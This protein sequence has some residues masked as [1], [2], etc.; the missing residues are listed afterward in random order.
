MA[1]AARSTMADVQCP[2]CDTVVAAGTTQCPSCGLLFESEPTVAYV[3]L[4]D[5]EHPLTPDEAASV[6]GISGWA[7]VVE[8]GPRTGMT[9][10]LNE[11]TTAVGRQPDSEILLD[12]VTVSR[13][14][15]QFTVTVDEL[16]VEDLGSTNGTYVNETRVDQASLNP[17]DQVIIG[18]FQFLVARG[19]G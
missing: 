8:K 2:R 3:E 5:P 15:C 6:D 18:R 17:G 19:D 9:F 10:V 7:L 16:A 4:P 14:H 1:T 13:Q 11:G 12:D